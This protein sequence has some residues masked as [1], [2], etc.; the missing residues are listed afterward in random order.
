MVPSVYTDLVNVLRR[1]TTSSASRDTFNNP[2]YGT[3][4]NWPVVYTNAK[5]RVSLSGKKIKWDGTGNLIQ[6]EGVLYYS[7]AYTI[8]PDDR[9]VIQSAPGQPTGIEYVVDGVWPVFNML[10]VVD[11]F[12]GN[13]RLPL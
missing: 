2:V 11:H 5:V 8:Q 3:P 4:Q 10:G 12:Q 1:K 13:L 7:K 9:I 6:F